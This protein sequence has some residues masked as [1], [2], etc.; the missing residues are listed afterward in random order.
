MREACSDG[1]RPD[2]PSEGS[3]SKLVLRSDYRGGRRDGSGLV[4]RGL[5]HATLVQ[6]PSGINLVVQLMLPDDLPPIIVKSS[7]VRW[8]RGHEFGMQREEDRARLSRF[9]GKV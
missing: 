4:S 1:A 8:S 6:V 3:V 7:I 5:S 9:I 2:P